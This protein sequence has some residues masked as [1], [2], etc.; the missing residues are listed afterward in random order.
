MGDGDADG[1]APDG[2]FTRDEAGQEVLV[3]ARRAARRSQGR[4][5]LLNC[6]SRSQSI[7][8]AASQKVWLNSRM[9]RL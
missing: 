4:L 6:T 2:V 9:K 5:P 8:P 1:A 7:C 3:F